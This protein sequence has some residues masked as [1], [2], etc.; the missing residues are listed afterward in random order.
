MHGCW[1][2]VLAA[3]G[4]A[5]GGGPP[6]GDGAEPARRAELIT[7][8]RAA[9]EDLL[10]VLPAAIDM[11][12]VPAGDR[13][14]RRVWIINPSETETLRVS[15]VRFDCGCVTTPSFGTLE[16][17]PGR[18]RP[19]DL[20]IAAP[21]EAGKRRDVRVFFVLDNGDAVFS[22]I[23]LETVG[24]DEGYTID[25]PADQNDVLV[26]PGLS[27]LGDLPLG[28]RRELTLWLIN[29]S[30]APVAIERIK[31]S[32]PCL[33]AGRFETE[34][35]TPGEAARLDLALRPETEPLDMRHVRVAVFNTQGLV[36]E[37][38]VRY[39]VGQ[40]TP[41]E[42]DGWDTVEETPKK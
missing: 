37:A 35:I 40:T 11:G 4:A 28:E 5:V 10:V 19:V 9:E 27:E 22:T 42:T 31:S 18:A 13:R 33:S 30:K 1:L 12:R 23:A 16:L 32:C 26:L 17:K 2:L 21:P 29:Q 8:E 34:V 36:G 7:A 39:S 24:P 41:D 3:A 6:N 15:A 25:P 14:S 20:E 38:E